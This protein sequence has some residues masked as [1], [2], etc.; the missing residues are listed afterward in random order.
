MIQASL[1]TKSKIS[2]SL[3]VSATIKHHDEVANKTQLFAESVEIHFGIESKH[4]D[5]DHFYEVNKFIEGNHRYFYP[6]EDPD[7]YRLDMG[8]ED[9][10]VGDADPQSLIKLVTGKFLKRSKAPGLDTMHNEVLRLG[11]TTSLFHQLA[12]LFTSSMQLGYI[13]TAWKIATLRMLLKP[14]KLPSLT[15]SYR[16]ISLISSIMKLFERDIKQRL[17]SHLEK[18]GFLNKHQSGFRRAKSTCL[19]CPNPSWKAS[20]EENM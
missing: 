6:P 8:S 13:P 15:T 9:E 14:D 16:P 20:T 12:K 1:G 10:L 17:T 3:R 5:S 11:T 7:D 4:F 18:V 19:D 2:S